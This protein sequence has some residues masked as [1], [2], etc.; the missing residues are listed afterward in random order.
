MGRAAGF[1]KEDGSSLVKAHER[2]AGG[3]AVARVAE[4]SAQGFPNAPIAAKNSLYFPT[5]SWRNFKYSV[6]AR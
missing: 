2:L 3:S 4:N 5:R 6:L 1:S